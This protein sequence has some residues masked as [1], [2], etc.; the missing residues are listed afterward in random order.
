MDER[1]IVRRGEFLTVLRYS[2]W[3]AEKNNAL[4]RM[5]NEY[6]FDD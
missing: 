6:R 3:K 1:L 4:S 5:I 2:V